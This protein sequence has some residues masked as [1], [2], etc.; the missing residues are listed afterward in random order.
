MFQRVDLCD[1]LELER[2]DGLR[3]E[4]F[5]AD[6]L[7]RDALQ[8]VADAAGVEPGWAVRIEKLIPVAAGLGGGSSDAATALAAR[9]RHA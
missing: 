2:S 6:T 5:A 1:R 4:G 3:V 8:G 7:V 9:Q